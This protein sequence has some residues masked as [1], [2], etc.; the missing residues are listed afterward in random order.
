MSIPRKW[1]RF[2]VG[3][4]A[5]CATL[6]ACRAQVDWRDH[7][8]FRA[9]RGDLSLS[10]VAPEELVEGVISRNLHYVSIALDTVFFRNLPGL[11][12]AS[13]ALG[14]EILGAR[15]DGKPLKTVLD[16]QVATPDSGFLSFDNV[17]MVEPFLYTGRNISITLHFKAI[18]KS[19][20][21]HIKGRL[22]G[23]G[24]L[25]K[26]L[27]PNST[28]ALEL[29]GSLFD[30]VVGA[31]FGDQQEFKYSFTLYPA[32]S[33][34]RDK[35]ELL[36]TAARHI[37]LSVPPPTA[38][39]EFH[40]LLPS[41]LMPMLKLRGNRLVFKSSAEEYRQ[42]PYIILNVTRYKRYPKEDTPLRQAAKVVDG[43]LAQGN[44][45]YARDN[46]PNL[47]LA[48]SNDAVITQLEKDLERSWFEIREAK[49]AEQDAAEKQ[50][51]DE[52]LKQKLRQVRYLVGMKQYFRK[53]LE[54]FEL[55]QIDYE[56]HSGLR[57]AQEL[58]TEKRLAPPEDAAKLVAA[59]R[60]ADRR[61][62]VEK[63]Q[64]AQAL[65]AAAAKKPP[66]QFTQFEQDGYFTYKPLYQRWW[67][68]ATVLGVAGGTVGLTYMLM[69]R[70][71]A[72]P[73]VVLP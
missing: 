47:A 1:H 44:L 61:I 2:T 62:V 60:D 19:A 43:A 40:G 55:K 7:A 66:P 6:A 20:T 57:K 30:S 70:E 27:D 4:A 59:D 14:V 73:K 35:P 54:P 67:F 3:L 13:V 69:P 71:T 28:S 42:T 31:F 68:W 29:A 53:I 16:V 72:E 26:K 12:G 63:A 24:D 8:S 41:K 56:L 37:L 17:A 18:A 15:A 21:S 38:P 39:T 49:L 10:H 32:D 36:F 45:K 50:A 64:A 51:F 34:Y 65:A 23:A 52:V 25:I 33:V 11:F 48:I 9:T 5:L 46:M 22:A 58:A